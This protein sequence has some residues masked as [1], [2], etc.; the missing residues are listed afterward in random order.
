MLFIILNNVLPVF[1][2]FLS[3]TD[4][5][6]THLAFIQVTFYKI[7]HQQ[8]VT[9]CVMLVF[10]DPSISVN[11]FIYSELFPVVCTMMLL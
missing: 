9:F 2:I 6:Y 7:V 8:I 3:I 10:R 11:H 5:F 1:Y 4:Y